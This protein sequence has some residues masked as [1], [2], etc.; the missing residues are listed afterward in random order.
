MWAARA[1]ERMRS[2]RSSPVRSELSD[3]LSFDTALAAGGSHLLTVQLLDA[4]GNATTISNRR[5]TFAESHR[6]RPAGGGI[7]PG[8]SC[9]R[10]ARAGE[11]LQ[12]DTIS[13]AAK[14]RYH[15]SYR[16]KFP[17]PITYQFR[18]LTPH[19]ADF[20]YLAGTSNVVDVHER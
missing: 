19:E 15:A 5:L 10:R 9:S 7:G 1:M 2:S 18:I 17:G 13:T 12:F 11:W 4:A 3:D 6:E 8:S 16:F 20:L 14:G